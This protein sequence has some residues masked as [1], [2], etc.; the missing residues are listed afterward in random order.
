MKELKI[1]DLQPIKN[2]EKLFLFEINPPSPFPHYFVNE[3]K[4]KKISGSFFSMYSK[5][6]NT[7]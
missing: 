3:K 4:E 5:M 6:Q 7:G 1:G 2:L